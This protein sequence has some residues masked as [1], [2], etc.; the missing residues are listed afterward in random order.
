MN[1]FLAVCLARQ[2][3]GPRP[4]AR[5]EVDRERVIDEGTAAADHLLT[6]A[7]RAI[8]YT[9]PVDLQFGDF[10]SALLTADREMHPDD[11]KYRYRE[12][13]RETFAAYGIKT[14]SDAEGRGL[15]ERPPK[16]V[17]YDSVHYEAMRHDPAEVFRFIWENREALE[18]EPD[19]YTY[20]QSVRPCVRVSTDGFTLNETVAEYVQIADLE[21][22]D[23]KALGLRVP[24]RMS[25][26]Q[27]LRLWGG[28]TLIFDQY[29]QL[30]F[31]IGSGIR[32]KLQQRR[33]EY[34]WSTGALDHRVAASRRFLRMH[35]HRALHTDRNEKESW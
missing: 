13:L 31:H 23:L 14:T 16:G 22:A 7:I 28:G 34:L 6:M 30:R 15:W 19:A 21:A 12:R 33:I 8:D 1:A 26:S 5:L 18:I 25:P 24:R 11:D 17:S 2:G 9:P 10:V 29:G 32:S 4:S 35:I 20:V 3:L 27:K